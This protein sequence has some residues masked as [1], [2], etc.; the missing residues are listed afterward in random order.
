[1][2]YYATKE[3]MRQ[4]QLTTP[5][6]LSPEI[7]IPAMAVRDKERGNRIYEWGCKVFFFDGRKSLQVMHA[8]TK[9]VI[10]LVDLKQEELVWT[11]NMVANYLLEL[12]KE[13]QAMCRALRNYFASSPLACFDKI[14]DRSL[15]ASMNAIQTRLIGDGALFYDYIENGILHTLKISRDVNQIPVAKADD[16]EWPV[17]WKLFS[18]VIK[19][20]FGD[21]R[22]GSP[23]WS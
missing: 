13:D 5:E 8:K 16:E 20:H 22:K 3:T 6:Q 17:P 18:R 11:G 7:A 19:A 10:F 14:T 12:Y 21:T 15:I 1:M 2:I 4:Y 23:M 9:L